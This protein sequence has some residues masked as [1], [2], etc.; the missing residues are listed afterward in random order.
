[1]QGFWDVCDQLLETPWFD[2]TSPLCW[3]EQLNPGETMVECP[4]YLL[5]RWQTLLDLNIKNAVLVSSL[6]LTIGQFLWMDTSGY[7][8]F[9]PTPPLHG[10]NI[11]KSGLIPA[12][13][14]VLCWIMTWFLANYGYAS[15]KIRTSSPILTSKAPK[16]YERKKS[17]ST[18]SLRIW[19]LGT[20]TSL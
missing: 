17:S 6:P 12:S 10:E 4:G 19:C 5:T 16:L 15:P 2:A 8:F 20:P 18:Q 13:P 14:H 3:G 9:R 11:T 7:E 1:M